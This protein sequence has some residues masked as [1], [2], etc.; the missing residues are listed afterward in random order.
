M[1]KMKYVLGMLLLLVLGGVS[2]CN[3]TTQYSTEIASDVQIKTFSVAADDTVSGLD[4]LRFTINQLTG[5]IFN[6]DSFR[7]GVKHMPRKMKL[8]ISTVSSL[9]ITIYA[10]N[11]KDTIYYRSQED[12]IDFN[13][14]IRIVVKGYDTLNIKEYV[15]RLNVRKVDPDTLEWQQLSA[16]V[17]GTDYTAQRAFAFDSDVRMLV[18]NGLFHYL[19]TTP[20]TDGTRWTREQIVS[21]PSAANV[22]SAVLFDGR[23]WVPTAQDELYCSADGLA[24]EKSPSSERI[25]F[26]YGVINGSGATDSR[27]VALIQDRETGEKQ[28]A[29]SADGK[30][31][32]RSGIKPASDFP[33]SGSTSMSHALQSIER[34]TVVG[35]VTTAGLLT[36]GV[37]QFYMEKGALRAS[38]SITSSTL[39]FSPREGAS[40]ISYDKMWMLIGGR[41]APYDYSK[42]IHTTPDLGFTWGYIQYKIILPA[43]FKPRQGMSCFVDKNDFIWIIGGNDRLLLRDAWRGRVNRLSK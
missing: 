34:L 9:S 10:N 25:S 27:L 36:N 3:S 37:F 29:T 35:G 12:T 16:D 26:I 24:W 8:Q 20:I 1:I 38:S 41:T 31:W 18:S 2:S 15:A 43:D 42:E 23:L 5:E 19:Y 6:A 40:L 7:Y 4:E 11:D 14:P 22:K 17:F 13:N 21:L 30:T 33:I 28:F 39:S 32:V